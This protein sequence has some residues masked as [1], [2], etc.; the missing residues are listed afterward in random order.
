[1]SAQ[2]RQLIGLGSK[3]A[4]IA[5]LVGLPLVVEA[6]SPEA[7]QA[8]AVA[9]EVSL[10]REVQRDPLLVLGFALD[11]TA[12][13]LQHL[14]G[15]ASQFSGETGENLLTRLI[16]AIETGSGTALRLEVLPALGPQIVL[17]LDAPPIDEIAG[18]LVGSG[19]ELYST[20]FGRVGLLAE[21]RDVEQLEAGLRL[22]FAGA[23]FTPA[24]ADLPARAR[25]ALGA[26]PDG[27]DPGHDVRLNVYWEI[28]GK[29]LALGFA[30]EW[31][32][33][34][35]AV[36]PEGRRLIDGADFA[37]VFDQLDPHPVT[38]TYVNLPRLRQLVHDSALVQAVLA[39]REETGELLRAVLSPEL[40][41]VGMGATSVRTASGVRTASFGPPWLSGGTLATGMLAALAMPRPNG[42]IERARREQTARD[43]LAIG[44]ACEQFS[45]DSS[46]FPGPTR[47]FVPIELIAAFLEPVYIAALP[48]VDGWDNPLLY[49]SDG[50]SYRIVSTGGDG[51]LDRDWSEADGPDASDENQGDIVL[52]DGR[53]SRGVIGADSAVE[54]SAPRP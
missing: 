10:H 6:G 15:V 32:R 26:L 44:T 50:A 5:A 8:R 27:D 33:T 7:D 29:R 25:F 28:R 47:G 48:R 4:W 35:L 21:V 1:M 13:S 38:L 9:P 12:A 24:S 14:I 11:D 17:T 43:M 41:A 3:T 54:V 53:L 37:R 19:E 30:P 39:G 34:T 20:L 36:R 18:S 2:L 46:S 22:L 52:I 40:M 49:W 16:A 23:E 45:A 31:V 51:K 42:G